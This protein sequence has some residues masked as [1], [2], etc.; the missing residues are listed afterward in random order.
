[1]AGQSV[2][3]LHHSIVSNILKNEVCKNFL[4]RSLENLK[5]KVR[6]NAKNIAFVL[7]TAE[8]KV[9]REIFVNSIGVD[10]DLRTIQ[11]ERMKQNENWQNDIH[12][13]P[14][15]ILEKI[16]IKLGFITL[17]DIDTCLIKEFTA[18][19]ECAVIA[20]LIWR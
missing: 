1:M 4:R 16:M 3:L 15:S 14:Q 9:L 6:H 7:K 12:C 19:M 20:S 5:T 13:V 8:D 2:P 18:N 11:F 17:T 10:I